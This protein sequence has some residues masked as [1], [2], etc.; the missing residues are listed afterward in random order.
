MALARIVLNEHLWPHFTSK[1]AMANFW[2][3]SAVERQLIWGD[4]IDPMNALE[5]FDERNLPEAQ[6]VG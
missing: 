4:P 6:V 5:E 1:A 2:T 3:K